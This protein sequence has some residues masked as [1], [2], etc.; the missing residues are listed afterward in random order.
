MIIGVQDY[1]EDHHHHNPPQQRP[2]ASV[3]E[4]SPRQHPH[5]D[6]GQNLRLPRLGEGDSQVRTISS[7]VVH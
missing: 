4:G 7:G 2:G 1:Q 5:R 6:G 3:H